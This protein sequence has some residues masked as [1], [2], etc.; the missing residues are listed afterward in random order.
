MSPLPNLVHNF[1]PKRGLLGDTLLVRERDDFPLRAN[2]VFSMR[3]RV[4]CFIIHI[5]HKVE[6][7]T[8]RLRLKEGS[9]RYCGGNVVMKTAHDSHLVI[10]APKQYLFLCV[11]LCADFHQ[12]ASGGV[13]VKMSHQYH[14]H[15]LIHP[16]DWNEINLHPSTRKHIR[17]QR[18][19]AL[20]LEIIE[21]S[22]IW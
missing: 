1:R 14:T 7:L 8:P 19:F 5:Q 6:V 17:S 2:S 9:E 11:H 18:L 20:F 22:W 16:L 4:L 15:L 10:H 12:L 13:C 21:F 3:E